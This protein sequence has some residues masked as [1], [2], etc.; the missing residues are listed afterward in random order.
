M[1]QP[2]SPLPSIST[3]TPYLNNVVFIHIDANPYYHVTLLRWDDT[4]EP[5]HQEYICKFIF[6]PFMIMVPHWF[7]HSLSLTFLAISAEKAK[8]AKLCNCRLGNL[9]NKCI[10]PDHLMYSQTTVIKKKPKHMDPQT[11]FLHRD[12][13]ERHTAWS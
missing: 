8:N 13:I 11:F 6:Y 10:F 4:D 1:K 2:H 5:Y 3:D 12:F 7:S 9:W